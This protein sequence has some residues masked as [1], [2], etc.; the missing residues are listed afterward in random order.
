MV[1]GR[2]ASGAVHVRALY[3][4]RRALVD[5]SIVVPFVS[6]ASS[7]TPAK[8][9]AHILLL[10]VLLLQ[11]V[12]FVQHL[13]RRRQVGRG[14]GLGPTTAFAAWAAAATAA[15]L[16]G[17]CHGGVE[18][19]EVAHHLLVLVLLVGV[20]GL[21]VL[22]EVVETRELLAAVTAEGTFTGVFPV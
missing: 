9:I 4:P 11:L 13:G 12:I 18:R 19:G 8:G 20:D 22:A 3:M 1:V 15:G 2:T 6:R 5:N 16:V 14:G 7:W 10:H 17:C 21:G